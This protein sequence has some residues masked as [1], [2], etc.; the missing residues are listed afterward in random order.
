MVKLDS[1]IFKALFPL[2][3]QQI[4]SIPIFSQRFN[5]FNW[6]AQDSVEVNHL[7]V[8]FIRAALYLLR[9][10]TIWSLYEKE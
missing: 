6:K 1:T 4:T 3:L 8:Y 5:S 2:F 9:F 7:L 10:S